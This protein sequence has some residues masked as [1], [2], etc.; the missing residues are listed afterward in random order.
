MVNT[1]LESVE[2]WGIRV[3][4]PNSRFKNNFEDYKDKKISMEKYVTSM[5]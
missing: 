3:Q 4:N 2:L 1:I 5:W